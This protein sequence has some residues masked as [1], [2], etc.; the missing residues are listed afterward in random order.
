MTLRGLSWIVKLA[1]TETLD[2]KTMNWFREHLDTFMLNEN[3]V[4]T[5]S[6]SQ[7]LKDWIA[8]SWDTACDWSMKVSLCVCSLIME[9]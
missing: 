2:A 9:R 4:E 8:G 5:T 3:N 1:V 6:N 7:N